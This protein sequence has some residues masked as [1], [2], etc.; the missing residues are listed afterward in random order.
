MIAVGVDERAASRDALALGRWLAAARQEDLLLVWARRALRQPGRS[1]AIFRLP[2]LVHERLETKGIETTIRVLADDTSAALPAG[3]RARVRVVEADDAAA[4]LAH[5]AGEERA[6]LLVLGS[7]ERAGLGRIVPGSTAIRLLSGDAS[8]PV[9]VAP[10]H[11]VDRLSSAPV[12]GVG[13]DGGPESRRALAWA[14]ELARAV[15]GQLRVMAVHQPLA[16]GYVSTGAIAS[17]SV[18]EVLQRRLDDE[19]R[20]AVAGCCQTES[21]E[22]EFRLGDPASELVQASSELDLLVLGSRGR[23]PL[24]SVLLGSVSDATLTGSKAPVLVVPRASSNEPAAADPG[25][26]NLARLVTVR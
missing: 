17:Q 5:V 10:R 8:V 13:F 4:G 14:D 16:F 3:L 1:E 11:Y 24:R 12:I 2:G 18:N 20:R 7:S 15:S 19:V 25:D 26:K 21:I 23:G 9:A 22:L 6:S